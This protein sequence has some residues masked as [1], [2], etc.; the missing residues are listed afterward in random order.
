MSERIVDTNR[1][2]LIGEIEVAPEVL[3]VIAGI[4]ANEVDGV[5]AMQGRFSKKNEKCF[6]QSR[7]YKRCSFE[8]R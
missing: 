8:Y 2:N 1:T 5:Y 6:R 3:E 4:A 7:S